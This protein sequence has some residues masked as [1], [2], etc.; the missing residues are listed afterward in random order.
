MVMAL[1]AIVELRSQGQGN[2]NSNSADKQQQGREFESQFPIA[3]LKDTNTLT[4]AE[5]EKRR[6]KSRRYDG[7][8]NAIGENI[9]IITSS[10]HWAVGLPAL[11][12]LQSDAV[13]IGSIE[14]AKA[15]ITDECAAV[16]SEF[17]LKIENVLK[18]DTYNPLAVGAQIT[19][20]REGGRVRTS[21]GRI[22]ISFTNGMGMPRIGKRYLFF[23]TH[24][25]PETAEKEETDFYIVTAYELRD[26]RV[27]P[28]DNP[29]G[30]THPIA[31]KYKN[32]DETTLL[33]DLQ[34]VLDQATLN[35]HD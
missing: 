6:K 26:G 9:K 2:N 27:Y 8:K 19:I 23:L 22:G 25:F 35:P 34:V 3:N 32:A 4:H 14:N 10:R 15:F 7:Y 13:V 11:P 30:G 21:S 18:N 31:N 24:R 1:I 20:E 28:M 5:R 29:G 33:R 12:V 16:Y 17:E